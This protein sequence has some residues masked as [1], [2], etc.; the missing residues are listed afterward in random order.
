MKGSKGVP[1]FP[2][3]FTAEP[4]AQLC[5]PK[6]GNERIL[7]NRVAFA[8]Q[9]APSLRRLRYDTVTILL[10]L[11]I[12]SLPPCFKEMTASQE[13]KKSKSYD[14]D[15]LVRETGLEPVR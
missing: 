8:A 7:F 10:S 6:K 9:K 15:F 5:P 1:G 13:N 11:A 4:P 12:M 2:I 14:L 3:R